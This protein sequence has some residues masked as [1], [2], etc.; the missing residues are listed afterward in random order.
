MKKE[1]GM[2]L[3]GLGICTVVIAANSKDF[4]TAFWVCVLFFVGGFAMSTGAT[5][6]CKEPTP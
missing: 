2:D 3:F 1:I 6:F 5:L 4:L